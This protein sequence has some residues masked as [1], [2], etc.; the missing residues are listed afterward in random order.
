VSPHRGVRLACCSPDPGE[1]KA[2]LSRRGPGPAS[3][4][5]YESLQGRDAQSE[6][7]AC[8]AVI[9]DVYE[10]VSYRAR[11]NTPFSHEKGK[12]ISC[13]RSLQKMGPPSL[14][15]G[16]ARDRRSSLWAAS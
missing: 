14:M 7:S 6:L 3:T 10:P 5:E 11:G 9:E 13:H 1:G 4:G 8:Q 12:Q 2:S 16:S 15:I